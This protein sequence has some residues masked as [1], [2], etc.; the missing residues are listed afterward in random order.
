[1]LRRAIKS[2]NRKESLPILPF[3]CAAVIIV[4]GLYYAT[5]I[6]TVSLVHFAPFSEP[7]IEIIDCD[8]GE[9]DRWF[10][11]RFLADSMTDGTFGCLP[12]VWFQMVGLSRCVFLQRYVCDAW[13]GI[14]FDTFGLEVDG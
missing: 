3:V 6:V 4:D 14:W 8:R 5:W 12:T 13:Q 10:G 11:G 2:Q 7:D 9:R 1:M